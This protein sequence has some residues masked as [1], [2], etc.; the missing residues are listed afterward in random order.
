MKRY[1]QTNFDP[2]NC[3]QT[4]IA[5]ILEVEPSEL[6]PQQ[7]STDSREYDIA[8]A[9]FLRKR[10]GLQLVRVWPYQFGAVRPIRPEHV[11]CGTMRKRFDGEGGERHCVVARDGVMVWDPYPTHPGLVGDA[12]WWGVLA[13]AGYP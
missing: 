13:P 2:G 7:F 6:P 3:F 10:F 1:R 11:M 9:A 8:I 12:E 5:C 4:A